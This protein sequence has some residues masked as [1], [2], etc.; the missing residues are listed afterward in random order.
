MHPSPMAETLSE[1][2]PSVRC[3]TMADLRERV[4]T[5]R[6]LSQSRGDMIRRDPRMTSAK[7]AIANL[8]HR[9]TIDRRDGLALDDVSLDV[10]EGEFVAI[11]GPSG[12]GKSTL[13]NVVSG[14]F[15][16]TSGRAVV[17]G[18]AVA[19]LNPRIGYM[20]AR[21]ALL[22]WRTTLANVEFGL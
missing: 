22:P 18:A 2:F 7:I 13:L 6:I 10:A 8:S 21:D 5:A 14:L 17:D 12:C 19:G 4:G 1:L 11:V 9:F 20:F 3:C 16:P 15:P